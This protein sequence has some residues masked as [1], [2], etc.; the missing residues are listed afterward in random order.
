MLEPQLA[1]IIV[2]WWMATDFV[3]ELFSLRYVPCE[4]LALPPL[5][6]QNWKPH[7]EPP[8]FVAKVYSR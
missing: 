7:F 4:D 1:L 5:S 6:C 3:L 8:H 2:K